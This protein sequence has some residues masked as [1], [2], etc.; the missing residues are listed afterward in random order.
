M[1]LSLFLG[2]LSRGPFEDVPIIDLC[3]EQAVDAVDA[4]FAMVTFGEQHYNGYEPYCNPLLMAARLSPHLKNAYFGTTVNP[5]AFHHP[6][7]FVEDVN[8]V[9][10]LTRG[11]LIV[12]VSAGRPGNAFMSATDFTNYGLDVNRRI[13]IFDTKLDA[14]LKVWAHKPGDPPLVIK[15][16][17]DDC[18]LTGRMM[19][20]SYREGR[21]LIAI[22]TSGDDSIGLTGDRGWPV[23]LGPVTM[24]EAHRKFLIHREALAR[25]GCSPGD[26]AR[27]A[28]FSLVTRQCVLGETEDQAWE[29]AERML[30]RF[31]MLNRRDD[32][33]TL[34]EM[35]AVDLDGP[36]GAADP[37]RR[38]LEV[39]D[40][41][42]LCGTPDSVQ[43]QIQAYDDIGIPH[44]NI[45][46]TVGAFDPDAVRRSFRLFVQEVR[47]KLN[48]ETFEAPAVRAEYMPKH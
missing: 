17:F 16:D 40:A 31:P 20:M 44:L 6:M 22:G 28:K 33:R 36:D 43:R 35:A 8:A 25:A 13:E 14:M 15:N 21:P 47:P 12:G 42:L 7:R 18:A 29:T 46:F 5:I 1:H 39:L 24:R 37:F 32:K 4:G 19:P 27:L 48:L 3:L 10:V 38:N 26:V 11:K 34:R 45:R 2:P 9:D 30:G 41:W 23:F